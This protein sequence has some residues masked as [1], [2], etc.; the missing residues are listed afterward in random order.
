M[1]RRGRLKVSRPLVALYHLHLPCRRMVHSG[2]AELH[3]LLLCLRMV[4]PVERDSLWRAPGVK[5]I[6]RQET[7]TV[8]AEPLKIRLFPLA[9]VFR[10]LGARAAHPQGRSVSGGLGA[11]AE[12]CAGGLPTEN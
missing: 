2:A 1:Q 11:V 6:E 4:G 12:S 10:R 3:G 9:Q 8:I 5:K 7:L